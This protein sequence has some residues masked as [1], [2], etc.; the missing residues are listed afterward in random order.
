MRGKVTT[1]RLAYVKEYRDQSGK[2][3]RYLR[4]SGQ[5]LVPLP[6]APGSAEFMEAYQTAIKNKAAPSSRH[7]AGTFGRLAEDYFRSVEFA[8]LKPNSKALYHFAIDP[9]AREHGHRLIRDL[10]VDKARKIVQAIGAAKPGMAN[11]T[12][13]V[14]KRLMRYAI[15]SGWRNDNPFSTVKP[16]KIG[17]RHTWTEDEMAAYEKRWPLGTRERLAYALLLYTDQRGGDVVRMRR[18]DIKG[19]CIRV[20]QQKTG[21]E[22]M[23]PIHPALNA[24]MKAGPAKG[25]HLIGD[26]HGRP[27]I[28]PTLTVL[29]TRA[30][31]EAG[32][33]RHCVPH[34][35]RKAMMRR[36][37]EDGATTKQIQAISGHRSLREV[38]RYTL[39][40][41]QE[42]LARSAMRK[43]RE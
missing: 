20:K 18:A 30:A 36:L 6:G 8:N 5:R 42:R 17:S 7:G 40:A 24:A 37:A 1:I 23:I 25:L 35:L 43:L 22:L 19:G 28:R 4:R 13:A 10:P 41:E 27:I 33:P 14:L 9:V 2:V 31:R 26:E 34:G 38:E 29:I 12:L 32:L 15:E 21:T 16:Y 3:R 11:L 39:A